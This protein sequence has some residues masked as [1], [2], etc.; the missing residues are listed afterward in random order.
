MFPCC[1]RGNSLE[2]LWTSL[3]IIGPP[4]KNPSTFR[5]KCHA[6]NLKKNPGILMVPTAM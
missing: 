5:I 2:R 6:S 4:T 1:V 3:D